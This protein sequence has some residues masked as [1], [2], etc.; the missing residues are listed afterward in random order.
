MK[1]KFMR[2]GRGGEYVSSNHLSDGGIVSQLNYN[3]GTP[4]VTEFWKDLTKPYWTWLGP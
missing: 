4:S 1:D 3:L 2:S